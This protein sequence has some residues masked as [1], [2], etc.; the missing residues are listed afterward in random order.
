MNL[1]EIKADLQSRLK[2]ERYRH[3]ISVMHTAAALAM[4][5]GCDLDKALMAGL[6][7]DCS[8]NMSV[9]EQKALC[10][11][12]REPLTD[13]EL[14]NEHLL[15][16]RT[17]AL[18]ARLR[19]GIHDEDILRAISSHTTGRAGMSLLEKIIYTADYIEPERR[20][21]KGIS[22]IRWLAFHNLDRCI[23]KISENTLNYLTNTGRTIDPR[24]EETYRYYKEDG[25]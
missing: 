21:L 4:C 24:T 13:Y 11:R 3:T 9:E 5:H 10:E 22:E 20:A 18:T 19:D 17:G 1:S 14:A 8:K 16:A 15:H 23:F 2:P 6:L 25:I 7:H 12:E